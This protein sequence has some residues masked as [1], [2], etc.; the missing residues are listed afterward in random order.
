MNKLSEYIRL[1]IALVAILFVGCNRYSTDGVPI[2]DR[3][4]SDELDAIQRDVDGQVDVDHLH[5]VET[6]G[7]VIASFGDDKYHAEMIIED[8]GSIDLFVLGEDLTQIGEVP[9]QQLTAYA[10]VIGETRSR[11]ILLQPAPNAG[12]NAGKTSRFTGKLPEDYLAG[13]SVTDFS[14]TVAGLRI[15]DGRYLLRFRF[16]HEQ[17]LAMPKGTTHDLAQTLYLI[18]GGS[19][20]E[21]DIEANGRTTAAEKYA[22]FIPK[23]DPSPVDGDWICPITK[24]KANPECSW[25]IA[26]DTYYFCCPPCIDE[27]LAKAKADSG[28]I[29]AAD[30]FKQRSEP[31]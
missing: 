5:D 10:K 26:G 22:G 11:A 1:T 21:E 4:A 8:D 15:D 6:M 23:H 17:H 31:E 9:I 27:F 12:D 30:T 3:S 2:V 18:S 14:L 25:I 7:G 28:N 13:N 19:Y 20:T 29:A 16:A 24:T